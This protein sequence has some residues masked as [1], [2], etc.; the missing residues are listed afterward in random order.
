M[1]QPQSKSCLNLSCRDQDAIRFGSSTISIY[2]FFSEVLLWEREG[3]FLAQEVSLV[4][5]RMDKFAW[6]MYNLSMIKPSSQK[7]LSFRNHYTQLL[8]RK[9]I[10]P[11]LATWAHWL[12]S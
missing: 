4:N 12:A 7:L 6:L 11:A 1:K 3:S 10:P 8:K 9:I 2:F 5:V